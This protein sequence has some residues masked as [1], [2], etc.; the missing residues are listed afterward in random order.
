MSWKMGWYCNIW[1]DWLMNVGDNW[2]PD[3]CV[4]LVADWLDT[5]VAI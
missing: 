1:Y 4:I 5:I 3:S 2:K